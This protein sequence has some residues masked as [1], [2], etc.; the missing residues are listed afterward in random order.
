MRIYGSNKRSITSKN[1]LKPYFVE[2]RKLQYI[3]SEG[4]I[5][6]IDTYKHKLDTCRKIQT[7]EPV[8]TLIG[9]YTATLYSHEL[10]ECYQI[11]PNHVVE[12]VIQHIYRL[13]PTSE[14]ECVLEY[15]IN[16]NN[17]IKDVYLQV[18]SST[19]DY[20]HTP[21]IKSDILKFFALL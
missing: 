18:S 14:V 21:A 10:S 2:T 11:A 13:T 15:A 12:D 8:K 19:P 17:V 20:I 9:V 7:N 4:E 5:L 3:H 16:A 6:Q 1:N